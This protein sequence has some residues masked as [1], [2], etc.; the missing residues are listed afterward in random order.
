MRRN[1]HQQL[2]ELKA[3]LM[4][5]AHQVDRS[6]AD[7]IEAYRT[8]D[9]DLSQRVIGAE[10]QINMMERE[11]DRLAIDLL[12]LEQPTAIDLRFILSIMRINS[13]LER[14]GDQSVSIA[15]RVHELRSSRPFDF[16]VDIPLLASHAREMFT[17]AMR[18]FH[19]GDAELANSVIALDDEVDTMNAEAFTSLSRLIADQPE[20][21]QQAMNM[22]IVAR[23]IERVADHATNIAEDVIFW[24]R[25][26]DIRHGGTH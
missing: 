22:L 11:I 23:N 17:I 5:M 15:T 25:G 4:T 24:R 16:H 7:S 21:A 18:S 13:D 14:V 9:L 19:E 3:Q 12:A 10:V 2:D 8:A 20:L 6:F 26:D 1:F